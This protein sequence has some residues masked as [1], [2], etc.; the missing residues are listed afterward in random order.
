MPVYIA[1]ALG[2]CLLLVFV[3][4]VYFR[5]AE[6]STLRT[7]I[8]ASAHASLVA[9]V[10]PYGLFVDAATKG[11]APLFL[12]LPVV[13]LLGLAALSMVYSVRVF[14]TRRLLHLAHLL[15]IA[16]GIPLTFLGSV[17]I[18]GWT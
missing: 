16:L 18:V 5:L 17:A 9:A 14:R 15:T 1:L 10:L 7:R 3:S 13:L 2:S 6:A 12:Q 4:L 11:E 8:A